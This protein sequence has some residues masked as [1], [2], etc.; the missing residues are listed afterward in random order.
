[1]A[2]L[3]KAS[4]WSRR[5]F[6][7]DSIPDNRTIRRWIENGLLAGRVVDGSIFV[8]DSEKWGVSSV[9]N[10]AVLQLIRE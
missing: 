7:H 10:S 9:V 3:M 4:Q 8:Y 1:M 2:K 5:E 6:T